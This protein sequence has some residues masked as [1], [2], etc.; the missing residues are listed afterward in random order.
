MAATSAASFASA[1]GEQVIIK[2]DQIEKAAGAAFE[3]NFNLAELEGVGFSGCE[4]AIQYDP[5][6]L[7]DVKIAEGAVLKTDAAKEELAKAPEIGKEVTMVNGS[8]DY[9]CFDY[10]V[11]EVDGKNVIAVL[12]CTGLD[13]SKSWAHEKGTIVTLTGTVAEDVKDGTKIPVEMV[14]IP[15]EGNKSMTFGY[16][17]G[18][19]DVA[20][21]SA[22]ATQGLI[23]VG[24]GSEELKP[25]WGD[26]ND[27][28]AVSAKD[29]VAM[30][31]FMV[32][33]KDAALTKQGIVNGNMDQSDG[34]T[35]LTSDSILG[36]K[37]FKAL[38]KYILKDYKADQFPIK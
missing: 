21:T 1:A 23:T 29:L 20:L 38:K 12:W 27:D 33:P 3:L 24:A 31:Q 10:N 34:D 26:V 11:K 37:D 7:K 15:R 19:K 18:T 36:A 4:F 30:M 22:V 25:L 13:S 8:K 5:A 2:G 9:S 28:G 14:A 32:S 6:M 16:V 35:D 17:D